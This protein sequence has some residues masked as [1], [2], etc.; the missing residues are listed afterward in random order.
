M[1]GWKK[2]ETFGCCDLE[3]DP[4][5]FTSESDLDML[6]LGQWVKQFKR[7]HP[8]KIKLTFGCCDFALDP[9]TFTS[10]LDLDIGSDLLA[11]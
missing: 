6:K 1:V 7:Y 10:E 9:V 3:L 8:Q 4:I 5:T 2:Y 11:C